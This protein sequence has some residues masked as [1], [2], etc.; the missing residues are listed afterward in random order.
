MVDRSTAAL[1][2]QVEE[3]A[4]RSAAVEP[5]SQATAARTGALTAAAEVRLL[6]G[7]EG[8]STGTRQAEVVKRA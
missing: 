3:A 5:A 2:G 8:S 4:S 6:I 1:L 7:G